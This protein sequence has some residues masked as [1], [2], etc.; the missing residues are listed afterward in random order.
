[1][2]DS[3]I[4]HDDDAR[5]PSAPADC[6]S[7]GADPVVAAHA[8]EARHESNRSKAARRFSEARP[9]PRQYPK[10]SPERISWYGAVRRCEYTR[11]RNYPYYGGRGI[12][13]CDRWRVPGGFANF[14]ADM[15]PRP[16]PR[17]SLDR[18]D[19]N[20]NYEPS[21]CRWTTARGQ[22]RN[23]RNN[24]LITIDGETLSLAEWGERA[25]ISPKTIQS[26]IARGLTGRDLLAA[27]DASSGRPGARRSR[28]VPRASYRCLA[29]GVTVEGAAPLRGKC[30]CTSAEAAA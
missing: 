28:L 13:V 4:R 3:P 23:R 1:M 20:G 18:I 9:G 25:G 2:H 30:N 29:C 24:T 12:K 8:P 10:M 17:H 22:A 27:P 21:N 19:Y 14:L 26:R 5:R 6:G 7:S 16:S 11:D 15:G